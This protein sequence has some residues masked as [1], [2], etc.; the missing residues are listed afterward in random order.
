MKE[1]L[2]F[3]A[4]MAAGL[5]I[6]Y[7][8]GTYAP[9]TIVVEPLQFSWQNLAIIIGSFLFFSFVLA[10]FRHVAGFSFKF[11]LVL[12]TIAGSQ[13]FFAAFLES[14]W[15]LAAAIFLGVLMIGGRRIITHNSGIILG[16]AGVSALLGLSITPIAALIFIS[17]LSVYDIISVYKTRHMVQLAENMLHSGAVFGF[18]IPLKYSDFFMKIEDNTFRDRCMIL[19]SGDIGLPIMFAS[20]LVTTSLSDALIVAVFSAIGLFGTHLLFVNQGQRRAMAALPPIA[21]ASIVGY[22]LTIVF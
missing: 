3:A 12:V 4:A 21:T 15:D 19:G 20:S 5:F 6:A 7:H 8:Y 11:F 10:R 22:L 2:L 9:D 18:L 13:L 14:P 1:L 17:V 16:I